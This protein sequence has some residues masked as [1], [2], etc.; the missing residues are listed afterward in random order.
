METR[1]NHV[2]VGAFT[3][4]TLLAG[5]LF[6]LWLGRLRLAH[7][8]AEYDVVFGE[9][10]TGLM[11]GSPVQHSGLLVGE[12]RKLSLDPSDFGRV[13]ARVRVAASSPVK[14]DT[15]ARLA[16]TGLTGVAVVQLLGGTPAAPSR[17]PAPGQKVATVVAEPSAMQ[18]L[19]ASGE[20]VLSS[21]QQVLSRLRVALN[22]QNLDRIAGTLDHVERLTRGVARHDGDIGETLEAVAVAS[23]SL[24]GL[25]ART[26]HLVV[27]L[28]GVASSSERV[29]DVDV[30]R[31]LESATRLADSAS[32]ILDENRAA[33]AS[34]SGHDLG[35]VGPALRD[36]REAVRAL[37]DVSDQLKDDPQSLLRG[38]K[39]RP[40]ERVA[41]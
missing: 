39:E 8:W 41:R 4:V 35:Q 2:L 25:L 18:N 9:P 10:V 38:Q 5:A 6:A 26:Q 3:L 21:A 33:I 37:R 27:R 32:R 29:L 17:L 30:R 15:R 28:E 14:V 36:L 31:T 40:R 7:E 12:V 34:F 24:H 1:A 19:L 13:V 20:A 16:F 11:V 23:R 22:S